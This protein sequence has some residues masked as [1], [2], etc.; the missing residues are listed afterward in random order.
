MRLLFLLMLGICLY[1]NSEDSYL[2]L[3]QRLKLKIIEEHWKDKDYDIAKKQIEEYLASYRD[4]FASSHLHWMLGDLYLEEKEY[5]SALEQYQLI[6][7]PALTQK[8]K[9]HTLICL[10]MLRRFEDLQKEIENTTC[11]LS[12]FAKRIIAEAFFQEGQDCK[13]LIYKK[14]L[15]SQAKAYFQE[16]L[17]TSFESTVLHPLAEIYKWLQEY[18]SAGKTYVLLSEKEEEK[19]GHYLLQAALMYRHVDETK[20][21]ELLDKLRWSDPSLALQAT[22]KEIELLGKRKDFTSILRLI[23]EEL[24][25]TSSKSAKATLLYYKGKAN[26]CLGHMQEASTDLERAQETGILGEE[27]TRKAL[28]AQMYCAKSLHKTEYADRILDKLSRQ[29]SQ[30]PD[31][32]NALFVH[33]SLCLDNKHYQK[34][35]EDLQVLQSLEDNSVSKDRL[36]LDEA[37]LETRLGLPEKAAKKLFQFLKENPT[38]PL[39]LSALKEL[40]RSL[41]KTFEESPSSSHLPF[42]P[43]LEFIRGH[44]STLNHKEKGLFYLLLAKVQIEEH[45]YE[46]ALA[47]LQPNFTPDTPSKF[48]LYSHILASTAYENLDPS[49]EKSASHLEK[50]IEQE[51]DLSK[52]GSL[53]I[54]LFNQML[55]RKS[56]YAAQHLFT[57]F[58]LEPSRIEA[59]NIL[60]LAHHFLNKAFQVPLNTSLPQ[61]Q[62]HLIYAQNSSRLFL[63]LFKWNEALKKFETSDNKI[64]ETHLPSAIRLYIGMQRY[65]EAMHYIQAFINR[66]PANSDTQLELKIYLSECLSK[67]KQNQK[68]LSFLNQV[69]E[70]CPEVTKKIHQRALLAKCQLL[71][72]FNKKEE[73]ENALSSLKALEIIH[74]MAFEPVGIE[75]FLEDIE[76]RLSRMSSDERQKEAPILYAELKKR[77]VPIVTNMLNDERL[78][79]QKKG[80]LL[81]SY[82]IFIDAIIKQF[83]GSKETD[84]YGFEELLAKLHPLEH[85]SDI[86]TDFL[87]RRIE[88]LYQSLR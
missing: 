54:K 27:M 80:A 38:N 32:K 79:K 41:A 59:S 44:L 10:L 64:L 55:H 67:R 82:L 40:M 62:E 68:A 72:S 15:F 75:A 19:K 36:F 13:D 2:A 66:S 71:K 16:L 7:E 22:I 52:K 21:L 3:E 61:S 78:E 4:G 9:E 47:T 30:E 77:Y 6:I 34:A 85:R 63:Y 18:E 12:S 5:A 31:H 8:A 87:K 43:Q 50:A 58:T 25:T 65:E 24:A 1:A 84:R 88:T 69:L 76:I 51:E 23:E 48:Q 42:L 53:H 26:F 17:I 28:L 46:E 81:S 49:Y 29:F 37:I 45:K 74:Q 60:W 57:A 83:T 70:S 11:V 35:L 39:F 56:D 86:D 33:L 14:K 73:L 20:A